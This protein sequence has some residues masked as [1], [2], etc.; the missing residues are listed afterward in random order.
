[1][2]D[3][4]VRR[5]HLV[6]GLG[7][8][9]GIVALAFWAPWTGEARG[10]RTIQVGNMKVTCGLDEQPMV[11]QVTGGEQVAVECIDTRM[12]SMPGAGYVPVSSYAAP[13]AGAYR[14]AV[15]TR[16]APVR[17]ASAATAPATAPR[18]TAQEPAREEGRSW[19]KTAMIIGGSTG[20]GAGIG[21]IAGGKKGA[22]IGAAIGGGSAAI[23]EA[24]KRK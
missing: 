17:T 1:M 13:N 18:T 11:R 10:G 3:I 24:I 20:A 21:A 7:L 9:A 12:V 8:L 23:F 14:P 19:K 5:S 2:S 22:L 4:A 6:G 15:Y 16:P